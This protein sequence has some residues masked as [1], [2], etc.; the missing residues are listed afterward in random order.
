MERASAR[1]ESDGGERETFVVGKSGVD[2]ILTLRLTESGMCC[3]TRYGVSCSSG[4]WL[5]ISTRVHGICKVWERCSRTRVAGKHWYYHMGECGEWRTSCLPG[6]RQGDSSMSLIGKIVFASVKYLRH[7][8][9]LH[10]LKSS[11]LFYPPPQKARHSF[12]CLEVHIL[13][14]R[15]ARR[16]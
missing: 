9:A 1:E 11:R 15:E 3:D 4:Q 5:G 16:A 13:V 2:A 8:L 10:R 7:L 12:H 14:K 6:I